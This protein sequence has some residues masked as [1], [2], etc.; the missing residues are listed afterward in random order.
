[1]LKMTSTISAVI[2]AAGSSSRMG[3]PKQV[4][5]LGSSTMLEHVIQLALHEDFAEVITVIGNEA[6]MIKETI[7]I[8]NPRFH[9]IVNENHLSGQSTSLKAGVASVHESHNNIMVFLGDTPFISP[10]TIQEVV[11]VAQQKLEES[12]ESFVIR[13]VYRGIAG[14]P[15]FFGNINKS[16]FT[17]L[18]GDVGAKKLFSQVTNYIQ[19]DVTDD[20]IL[21]DVDTKEEY[22]RAKKRIII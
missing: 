12:S 22:K 10:A 5:S 4:L 2:L 8:E 21:F 9:W 17:Q 16:L 13:P 7:L 20:G 14:H 11:Q 1:M 19:V 3:E 6:Q 15:V 18:E